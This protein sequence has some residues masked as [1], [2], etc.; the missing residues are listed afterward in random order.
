VGADSTVETEF[1]DL[2]AAFS[3]GNPA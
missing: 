2:L 3:M 1:H